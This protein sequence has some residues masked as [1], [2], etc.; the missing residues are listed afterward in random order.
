MDI[1][2]SQGGITK[3]KML[4]GKLSFFIDPKI[5]SAHSEYQDQAIGIMDLWHKSSQF[6]SFLDKY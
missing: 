2:H 1:L 3:M 5:K 6:F 4:K